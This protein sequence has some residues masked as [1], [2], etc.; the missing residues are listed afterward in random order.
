M[1][2]CSLGPIPAVWGSHPAPGAEPRLCC[3]CILYR[4]STGETTNMEVCQGPGVNHWLVAASNTLF[5]ILFFV[6]GVCCCLLPCQK[7]SVVLKEI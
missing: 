7:V 4:S 5:C 3:V 1:G 6:R 2:C